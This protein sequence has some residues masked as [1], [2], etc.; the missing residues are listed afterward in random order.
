MLT[1]WECL[2]VCTVNR[3][4]N[5]CWNGGYSKSWSSKGWLRVPR[6]NLPVLVQGLLMCEPLGWATSHG[7]WKSKK[8][9][10]EN[11]WVG[12]SFRQQIV[13]SFCIEM[14]GKALKDLI[15]SL[16]LRCLLQQVK[17]F[18]SSCSTVGPIPSHH[19][20]N[21]LLRKNILTEFRITGRGEKG[22]GRKTMFKL[23][24]FVS[25]AEKAL[26]WSFKSH[27]CYLVSFF[28]VYHLQNNK[29]QLLPGQLSNGITAWHMFRDSDCELLA[30]EE[31]K[32]LVKESC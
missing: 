28:S 10:G 24:S 12:F 14:K 26:S 30:A 13:S 29:P 21:F 15:L 23:Y 5:L 32:V 18:C 8:R 19:W 7:K 27:K 9:D 22:A 2:P 16:I 4:S 1:S 20:Q 11:K 3:Q 25:A 6:K 31:L 17:A